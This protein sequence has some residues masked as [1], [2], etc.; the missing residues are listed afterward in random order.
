MWQTIFHSLINRGVWLEQPC[1]VAG[2]MH[3]CFPSLCIGEVVLEW[4]IFVK[5]L[6]VTM[7]L[8][9]FFRPVY[10][11]MWAL[12]LITSLKRSARSRLA[13]TLGRWPWDRLNRTSR[14]AKINDNTYLDKKWMLFCLLREEIM[15]DLLFSSAFFESLVTCVSRLTCRDHSFTVRLSL[16]IFVWANFMRVTHECLATFLV[17]KSF[18]LF[19]Y[20][21]VWEGKTAYVLKNSMCL[22]SYSFWICMHLKLIIGDN[23]GK[24]DVQYYHFKRIDLLDCKI[25]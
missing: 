14:K 1:R 6:F 9:T 3:S 4:E 12:M 22:S 23:M 13:V 17:Y 21:L 18:L 10:S 16:V 19:I 25:W 8:I 5:E 2:L 24:V 11:L 7:D 15:V 20:W